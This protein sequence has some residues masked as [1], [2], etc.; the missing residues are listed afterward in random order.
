LAEIL[1]RRRLGEPKNSQVVAVLS[2]VSAVLVEESSVAKVALPPG[3]SF[4]AMN[5]DIHM[6]M[7]ISQGNAFCQFDN[8]FGTNSGLG[9]YIERPSRIGRREG[10]TKSG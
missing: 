10:A 6:S 5:N 3:N 7:T 2:L 8:R 1:G 4:S 9:P